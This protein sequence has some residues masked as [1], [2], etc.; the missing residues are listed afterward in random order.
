M[1]TKFKFEQAYH[2]AVIEELVRLGLPASEA[3]ET[4]AYHFLAVKELWGYELS[5]EGLAD[6]IFKLKRM[7]DK[8]PE[9]TSRPKKRKMSSRPSTKKMKRYSMKLTKI[10]EQGDGFVT[11]FTSSMPIKDHTV[12]ARHSVPTEV[13][14]D[15][16][17]KPK[18]GVMIHG[19]RV[20]ASIP[21]FVTDGKMIFPKGCDVYDTVQEKYARP[22]I[23]INDPSTQK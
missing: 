14:V 2:E 11:L 13:D 10:A 3:E 9:R 5:P 12:Y 1:Q 8:L 23:Q 4:F 15:V 16:F 22:I 7:G 20:R 19:Q 18:I 17:V 6:E 21:G